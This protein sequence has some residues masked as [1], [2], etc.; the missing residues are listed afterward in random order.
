MNDTLDLTRLVL[1]FRFK[2]LTHSGA[3]KK[4][5]RLSPGLVELFPRIMQPITS[6]FANQNLT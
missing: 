1:G 3:A 5:D 4:N 2:S 6:Q